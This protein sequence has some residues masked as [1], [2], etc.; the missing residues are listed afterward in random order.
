M[1]DELLTRRFSLDECNFQQSRMSDVFDPSADTEERVEMEL[2]VVRAQIRALS[3]GL[4][5]PVGEDGEPAVDV[6]GFEEADPGSHSALMADLLTRPLPEMRY[7]PKILRTLPHKRSRP[8]LTHE[9]SWNRLDDDCGRT[10]RELEACP[11]AVSPSHTGQPPAFDFSVDS[12]LGRSPEQHSPEQSLPGSVTWEIERT[13]AADLRLQTRANLHKDLRMLKSARRHGRRNSGCLD[14][15]SPANAE[16]SNGEVSR[17]HTAVVEVE[18]SP[19]MVASPS[20]PA[21]SPTELRD[22]QTDS[23]IAALQRQNS[24]QAAEVEALKA[25]LSALEDS[26]RSKDAVHESRAS[27][28]DHRSS[29]QSVSQFESIQAWNEQVEMHEAVAARAVQRE[30]EARRELEARVQAFDVV[31]SAAHASEAA[32]AAAADTEATLRDELRE[33]QFESQRS[34]QASAR[35]SDDLGERLRY[36]QASHHNL[37]RGFDSAEQEISNLSLARQQLRSE[38]ESSEMSRNSLERRLQSVQEQLFEFQTKCD[39]S[40]S[41]LRQAQYQGEAMHRELLQARVHAEEAD[42]LADARQQLKAELV[43]CHSELAEARKAHQQDSIWVTR[44]QQ[45]NDQ[46]AADCKAA[47]VLTQSLQHELRGTG[48]RASTQHA[49]NCEL[50]VALE[51]QRMEAERL[52]EAVNQ[53]RRENSMLW[54]QLQFRP[55]SSPTHVPGSSAFPMPAPSG[56][57]WTG[58][59]FASLPG[60]GGPGHTMP[61]MNGHS[62]PPMN[63]SDDTRSSASGDASCT[64]VSP[65][66]LD[67]QERSNVSPAGNSSPFGRESAPGP[68]ST[69][70]RGSIP[71]AGMRTVPGKNLGSESQHDSLTGSRRARIPSPAPQ[72]HAGGLL[73][74]GS[75]SKPFDTAGRVMQQG[76]FPR[77]QEEQREKQVSSIEKQVTALSSERQV[78]EA[79]LLKFPS[80]TSGRTLADRKQKREAEERIEE[81]DKNLS[82]LRMQLR[83]MDKR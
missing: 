29:L 4:Q 18:T 30:R 67:R 24:E 11:L 75:S 60:S 69:L 35:Y 21:P 13:A 39:A 42:H 32:A 55:A 7:R 71:A 77:E 66:E 22:W 73:G 56:G 23:V 40:T 49:E 59:A 46:L 79:T 76:H 57:G 83:Q 31:R 33:L 48:E 34:Q 78:L 26:D 14:P 70:P 65:N 16:A 1:K 53:G 28:H 51:T 50:R 74:G 25:Q 17:M 47:Q 52:R 61:P 3:R 12:S 27:L 2:E 37:Q 38:L 80:N 54:Q 43:Q 41:G 58:P 44:L 5:F 15:G 10:S 68:T 9:V 81:V 72:D 36:A 64:A 19:V 45:E 20:E 63:G 82:Q 62:A 6:V 8:A